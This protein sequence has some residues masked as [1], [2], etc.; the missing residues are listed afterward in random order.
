MATSL[1]HGIF[2]SGY[3]CPIEEESSIN[4]LTDRFIFGEGGN[5]TVTTDG[6]LR[7]KWNEHN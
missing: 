6:Y 4:K 2:V 3:T 7:V 1:S 5:S